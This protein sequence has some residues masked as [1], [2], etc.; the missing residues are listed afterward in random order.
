MNI[1]PNR[2]NLPNPPFLQGA[3]VSM[4][5]RRPVRAAAVHVTVNCA[6]KDKE[7]AVKVVFGVGD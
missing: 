3:V 6:D 4:P 2:G 5:F 1:H 7:S